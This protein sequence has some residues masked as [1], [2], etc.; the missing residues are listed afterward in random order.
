MVEAMQDCM[1]R[2]WRNIESAHR[3]ARTLAIVVSC[4]EWN[5]M[6]VIHQIGS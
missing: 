1:Y 6:S 5:H 4:T 2:G 3:Q